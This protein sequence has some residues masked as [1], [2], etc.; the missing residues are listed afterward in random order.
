VDETAPTKKSLLVQCS[1]A[2]PGANCLVTLTLADGITVIALTNTRQITFR[3]DELTEGIIAILRGRNIAPVKCSAAR[4]LRDQITARGEE[5]ALKA[6]ASAEGFAKPGLYISEPEINSLGYHYLQRT[7]SI[8][9]AVLRLNA[10]LFPNSW[11]AHDSLGEG[12]AAAGARDKAIEHYRKSL[13]LNAS[14]ENAR[15]LLKRLQP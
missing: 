4:A 5:A 1:G 2:L 3:L 9:V 15:A 14:N 6:A 10:T 8:A 11:N 12:Y 7:P 13:E